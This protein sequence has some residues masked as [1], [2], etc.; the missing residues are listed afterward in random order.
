MEREKNAQVLA[1]TADEPVAAP[2]LPK[3]DAVGPSILKRRSDQSAGSRSAVVGMHCSAQGHMHHV[4]T[5]TLAGGCLGEE[6]IGE[7]LLDAPDR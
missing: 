5:R 1:R 6:R 7:S 4:A 3:S 2:R